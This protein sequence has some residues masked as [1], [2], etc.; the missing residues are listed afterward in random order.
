MWRS[1]TQSPAFGIDHSAS[2][3]LTEGRFS[4]LTIAYEKGGGGGEDK[5]PNQPNKTKT[6]THTPDDK[7]SQVEKQHQFVNKKVLQ[8]VRT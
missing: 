8:G 7:K 1:Y 4:L 2:G 3:F 6:K 5:K